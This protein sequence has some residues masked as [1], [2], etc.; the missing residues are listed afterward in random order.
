MP[1][2]EKKAKNGKNGKKWQ[3]MAKMAQKM[4]KMAKNGK[5]IWSTRKKILRTTL[6]M[7]LIFSLD[8][9]L[10]LLDY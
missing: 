4:A 9:S 10:F 2:K 6:Y 5:I 1:I 8:D 7:T 3:K